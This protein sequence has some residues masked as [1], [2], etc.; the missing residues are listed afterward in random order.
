MIKFRYPNI[1]GA[2]PEERQLQMERFIRSMV[3]QMNLINQTPVSTAV[4]TNANR[5]TQ[6][7][8]INSAIK[9]VTDEVDKKLAELRKDVDQEIAGIKVDW[10]S[11][12]PIG[13]IYISVSDNSPEILFGG[14]WE[15]IKDQ[16][17]LAAGDAY[18]AGATG[19]EAEHQKS[20]QTLAGL[21][22]GGA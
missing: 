21:V 14:K 5:S 9:K 17:L 15:R 3:D 16:F 6:T 11:I 20:T 2:T 12:Y 7:P 4:D 18:S 8:S 13:S 1:T 19:G 10:K 22:G